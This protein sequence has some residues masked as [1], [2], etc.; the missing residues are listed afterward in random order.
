MPWPWTCL[1]CLELGLCSPLLLNLGLQHNTRAIKHEQTAQEGKGIRV[2]QGVRRRIVSLQRISCPARCNPLPP[3]RPPDCTRVRALAH[4]RELF[5]HLP[6]RLAAVL[7][8]QV[9]RALRVEKRLDLGLPARGC[10]TRVT[11]VA[12]QIVRSTAI[13]GAKDAFLFCE[14]GHYACMC[15]LG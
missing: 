4:L 8:R 11:R 1:L 14:A 5:L 3:P 13:N 7:A 6:G 9:F 12:R 10:H 15:C 2:R